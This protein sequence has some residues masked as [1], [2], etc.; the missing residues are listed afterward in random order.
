[1]T[2]DLMA[3]LVA[4]SVP[5]A[6]AAL[7][8]RMDL[9]ALLDEPGTPPFAA[10][11]RLLQSEHSLFQVATIFWGLWLLPLAF[12]C[13]RSRLV[14]RVIAALLGLA[15]FLYLW[16]FAGPLLGGPQSAGAPMS[17]VDML[18]MGLTMLG[19]LGFAI[20]LIIFGARGLKAEPRAP[21]GST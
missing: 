3:L 18:F 1:V 14:P 10:V 15:G 4:A 11:A 16:S 2:A 19:E 6:L 7:A 5:L 9:I 21:E 13:W 20:W 8:Q 12:L 17:G